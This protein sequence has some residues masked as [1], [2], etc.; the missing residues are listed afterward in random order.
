MRSRENGQVRL[1]YDYRVK[2]ICGLKSFILFELHKPV[3]VYDSMVYSILNRTVKKRK[4]YYLNVLIVISQKVQLLS[5]VRLSLLR[6]VH[7]ML[8]LRR[9]SPC[10]VSHLQALKV[11]ILPNSVILFS[12]PLHWQATICACRS[13]C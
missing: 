6:P 2:D 1:V 10:I 9:I 3:Y 13:N 12:A 7:N 5:A 4:L 11:T 8:Q